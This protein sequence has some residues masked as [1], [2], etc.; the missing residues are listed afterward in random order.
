MAGSRLCRA[1]LRF[2]VQ[3][4][5]DTVGSVPAI[6]A[7]YPLMRHQAHI[8]SAGFYGT[9]GHIDIQ[10][11]RAKELTLH[12]PSGWVRDRIDAT[13]EIVARGVLKTNLSLR[14][15]FRQ[16]KLRVRLHSSCRSW[17]RYRG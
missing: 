11:M 5:I 1:G 3:A 14:I 16:K 12:A 7:L 2:G 13:L 8:I 17:S 15:A 4:V 6:E 10:P 9:R